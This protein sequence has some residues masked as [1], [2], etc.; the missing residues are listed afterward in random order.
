MIKGHRTVQDVADR[1]RRAERVESLAAQQAKVRAGHTRLGLP[2][3]PPVN[4][5]KRIVTCHR[6]TEPIDVSVANL[7]TPVFAHIRQQRCY[8]RSGWMNIAVNR[9]VERKFHRAASI[10]STTAQAACC[11][12]T[13]VT[14]SPIE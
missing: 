5:Q 14:L 2:V 11:G 3:G 7:L 13:T 12:T 4:R 6:E 10:C 9:A 8:R 1:I